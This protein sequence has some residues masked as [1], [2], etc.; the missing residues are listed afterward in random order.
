MSQSERLRVF[1]DVHELSQAGANRFIELASKAIQ[2][3][4]RFTVS[5]SGGST[6][7]AMYTLLAQA[8][9]RDQVDWGNVVFFW[10][11]E[12]FVPANH[13][14]SNYRMVLEALISRVPVAPQNIF[15]VKTENRT[16]QDSAVDYEN[17]MREFF[18][19]ELPRF[20]LM[21]MGLGEDAHTAS[22]FPFGTALKESQRWV[23]EVYAEHLKA[24]RITMTLPVLN[25]ADDTLFLV[26]GPS[27]ANALKVVLEGPF[28]PMQYPA[29]LIQPRN[30]QM[31]FFADEASTQSR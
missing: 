12:R 9:Y 5:L 31:L 7:Q 4:G 23:I 10:G 16:P 8:P 29:Q 14:D 13:P 6:P 30:G 22:L 25:N 24:H 26:S 27:K 2:S 1:K 3:T 17:I 18:G 28:E 15:P 21:L 19:E 11:D 20:D